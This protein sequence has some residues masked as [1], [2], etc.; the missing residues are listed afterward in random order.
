MPYRLKK[1]G[2]GVSA[3][4]DEKKSVSAL[5]KIGIGR[6]LLNYNRKF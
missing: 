2:I 3:M 6:S 5:K 4:A 1:I